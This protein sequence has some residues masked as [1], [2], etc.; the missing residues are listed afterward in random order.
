M[1][2]MEMSAGYFFTGEKSLKEGKLKQGVWDDLSKKEE[3]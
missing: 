1:N 3:C 2:P